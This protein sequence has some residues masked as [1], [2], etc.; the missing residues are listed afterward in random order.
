MNS[1]CAL[2][3]FKMLTVEAYLIAGKAIVHSLGGL[4]PRHLL[5]I[6]VDVGCNTENIREDPLYIGL[7]Q[8]HSQS[9]TRVETRQILTCSICSNPLTGGTQLKLQMGN[10]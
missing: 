2:S 1:F 7:R 5:P 3:F 9:S 8:V 6:V 10:T 4:H